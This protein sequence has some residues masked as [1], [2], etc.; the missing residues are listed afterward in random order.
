MEIGIFSR[1]FTRPNLEAVLDAIAA[2]GI[3]QVHFNLKSADVAS[4][5]DRI[6]ED[7][8]VEIRHAFEIRGLRMTSVSGTFNAIHPDTRRRELDTQRT[9]RLIERCRRMGTSVVTLCTGT[10][11]PH[12]MWRGHADNARPDAWQEL[13]ATLGRLLPAAETCGVILGIEPEPNNV[14]DS[15]VKARRLLDELRSPH[16][17]IIMDGANLFGSDVSRMQEVLTEAFFLLAP[18]IV[19]VHAKDIP[20]DSDH[21][22]QAA[23]AGRLDWYTYCRLLKEYDYNGPVILH[24][25]SEFEVGPS[26]SF[27]KHHLAQCGSGSWAG[28]DLH[29]IL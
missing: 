2:H 22:S 3:S 18:D 13:L 23:G 20:G 27:V 24:S 16:V 21:A 11:D 29:A 8:C 12:D 25:L 4:L 6:D 17:K 15:A 14:I 9:C 1:T 5:P 28:K 7:L 19:L 26:V 10:R